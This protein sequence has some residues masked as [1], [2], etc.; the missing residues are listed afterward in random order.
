MEKI[1]PGKYFEFIYNLYRVNEDGTET[2]M[3]Q[4]DRNEPERAIFGVTQGFVP[5]LEKGLEG[6]E[7]GGKFNITATPEDGF[8]PYDKDDVVTLSRDIFMVDGKFDEEAFVPGAYVPMMTADGYRIDGL[9]REV[10][11]TD[12]IVDFNHPL[13]TDTVRFE[14]EVL[15]VRDATPEEL[16]PTCGCHGGCGGDHGCGDGCGDHDHGCCGD[17][18]GSCGCGC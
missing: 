16:H 15:A 2:L 6:V 3:H 5:A 18:G 17:K 11:P 14:G 7:A 12:V 1:E 8:G 13:A 10:T 9:I 4:M